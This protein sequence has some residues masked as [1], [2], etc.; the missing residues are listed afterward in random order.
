MTD[1]L[2][3]TVVDPVQVQKRSALR[4]LPWIG[5]VVLLTAH[6]VFLMGNFAPAICSPDANGYWAQASLLFNTGRT[7]FLPEADSQYIGI[8]WLVTD[9]GKYFS[10]Y[11]PGL[12]VLVGAVYWLFGYK[13]SV[14]VNPVLATLSLLGLFFLVRRLVGPGW[15]VAGVFAL[16]VNPIFNQHAIACDSHV[17][18]AF[19]LVWGVWLLLRWSENGKLW[20]IFLA[21]LV[22]GCIPAIRYPE[23]LFAIGIGVFLLWH[24]RSRKRIWLHYLAACLGA[25][26]P[27]VPLLIR[28]QLAF[29][30]FYRTAYALTKE[31]TG[32][33]W[34]YFRSHFAGYIQNLNGSGVGMFFALGV[35][36]MAAMCFSPRVRRVGV[37]LI[38]LVVPSTLLYMAYYWGNQR[39]A[40]ATLRF[41]IPT[42]IC[43]IAA[44]LWAL[45]WAMKGASTALRSTVVIVVL[46]LNFVWGAFESADGLRKLHAQKYALACVTDGIEKN[47]KHGDL[48]IADGG[49][50][51]HLDFVRHW[52][53]ADLKSLRPRPPVDRILQR[54]QR[55]PDRPMPMQLEKRKMQA[56]KYRGLDPWDQEYEMAHDLH[57]WAGDHKIYYIG[58]EEE[59]KQM[60]GLWFNERAFKIVARI[61]LPEPP[62]MPEREGMMGG[63]RRPQPQGGPDRMGPGRGR[64]PMPPGGPGFGPPGADMRQ[65]FRR[66][67]DRRRGKGGPMGR[68]AALLD[69]KELVVAE[70]VYRPKDSPE[71]KPHD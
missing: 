50:L 7:W 35:V 54:Q 29:G 26:I 33:G 13:A 17:A 46:A 23:A 71:K 1:A 19:C 18:V 52:R 41:L 47:L 5:L 20:E 32:F 14:L 30:A 39:M 64:F 53:L 65:R 43:Y 60:P 11:P 31:Q 49:L 68:M 51:Q 6:F 58:P 28:N 66:F 27:I 8:H 9:S 61:P 42:F 25:A 12:S 40:G 48:I 55:D 56:E 70:W 24:I 4:L 69:E 45:D 57:K 44:G 37:F 36:G 59:L 3:K 10:R 21:G 34:D 62:P 2:A 38:L 67:G 22:L 15:G 63:G 16:A